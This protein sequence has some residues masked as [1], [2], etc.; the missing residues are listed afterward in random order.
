MDGEPRF[1][2]HGRSILQTLQDQGIDPWDVWMQYIA[3][4]GRLD[5]IDVEA[6]LYGLMPL[7]ELERML[8]M[9][10]VCELLADLK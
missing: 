6:F 10:G 7:P 8:L 9:E 1:E 5:E 3:L 2:G 4:T